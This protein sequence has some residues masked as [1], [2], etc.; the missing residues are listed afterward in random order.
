M[1]D[2]PH[3]FK[4]LT[5]DYW[6]EYLSIDGKNCRITIELRRSYCDRGNYLAKVFDISKQIIEDLE[7][8]MK[9]LHIDY[10]D[11]WPRY[12][13]D[14]ERAIL[15]V[16]AWLRKRGEMTHLSYWDKKIIGEDYE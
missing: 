15:E 10:Q 11:G 16:E 6:N 1:T 3:N 2:S 5:L 12:Y 7:L 8:D 9:P 13:F 4:S 14:L